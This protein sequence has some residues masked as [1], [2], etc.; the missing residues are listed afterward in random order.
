MIEPLQDLLIA[1]GNG[2]E[3]A[4]FEW[5]V[6]YCPRG[7][8]DDLWNACDDARLLTQMYSYT[9]DVGGLV[10]ATSACVREATR[11]ERRDSRPVNPLIW[12]AIESAER[13]VDDKEPIHDVR[14]K[15]EAVAKNRADLNQAAARLGS[16]ILRR[17]RPNVVSIM[18]WAALD[19]TSKAIVDAAGGSRIVVIRGLASVFRAAL[20]EQGRPVPTLAQLFPRST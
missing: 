3:N 6:E 7:T 16:I 1:L 20:R 14:L 10:L 19:A 2:A 4:P 8:L 12:A 17:D 13:W 9:G 15:S 5:V 18:A 11:P